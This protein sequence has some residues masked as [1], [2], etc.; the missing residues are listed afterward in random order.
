MA[1]VMFSSGVMDLDGR[2]HKSL[3]CPQRADSST[4]IVVVV[5]VVLDQRRARG[6]RMAHQ[7][8]NQCLLHGNGVVL[9]ERYKAVKRNVGEVNRVIDHRLGSK[10]KR[11][12][13]Q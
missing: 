2:R 5:V 13:R 7:P 8:V 6:S 9:I 10:R 11:G 12:R 4:F 3:V 1:R